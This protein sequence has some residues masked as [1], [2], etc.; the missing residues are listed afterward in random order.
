M[1]DEDLIFRLEGVG[2]SQTSRAGHDGDSEAD[3][4]EDEEY[5]ICPIT[6]DPGAHRRGSRQ[7]PDCGRDLRKSEQ[8]E[9]HS[10]SAS[11]GSSFNIKVRDR[12]PHPPRPSHLP[13]SGQAG[14]SVFPGGAALYILGLSL[15]LLS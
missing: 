12:G 13:Q 5:F 4:D 10:F 14:L 3:S 6:E 1:A 8:H 15:R 11:P 2:G 9:Q 7:V